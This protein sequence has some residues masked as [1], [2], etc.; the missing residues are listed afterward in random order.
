MSATRAAAPTDVAAVNV[1][2]RVCDPAAELTPESETAHEDD[3]EMY[4]PA[5]SVSPAGGVHVPPV[6]QPAIATSRAGTVV[7]TCP[8]E[9]EVPDAA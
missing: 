2:V 5:R 1:H 9:N 6:R 8:V 7:V 4:V 3:E